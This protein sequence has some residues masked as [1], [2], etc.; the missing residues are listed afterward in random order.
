MSSLDF[1]NAKSSEC[2]SNTP[3]YGASGMTDKFVKEDLP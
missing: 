3:V 2:S 1:D